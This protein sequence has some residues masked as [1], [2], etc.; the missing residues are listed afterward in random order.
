MEQRVHDSDGNLIPRTRIWRRQSGE[1]WYRQ[2]AGD[3]LAVVADRPANAREEA[4]IVQGE[5]GEEAE[6]YRRRL[7]R[8]LQDVLGTPNG[9][10]VVT[11]TVALGLVTPKQ[12]RRA[13]WTPPGV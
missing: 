10:E 4:R 6:G 5:E 7:R 9:N 2:W 1:V 3:P 11:L 13:G 8:S 12:A